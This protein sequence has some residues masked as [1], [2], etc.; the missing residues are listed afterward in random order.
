MKTKCKET[1]R[2]MTKSALAVAE[3]ALRVAREALPDYSSRTSRKDFTCARHV[4][5]LALKAFFKTDYRGVVQHLA[6]FAELR[7]VLGLDKVPH[8][9]TV[10]K[11]EQRLL[12]KGASSGCSG[13]SSTAPAKAA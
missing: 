4:A 11:A 9:S 13:I 7:Q 3:Q 6:D 10:K 5:I 8:Y 1:T 2:P 12:K